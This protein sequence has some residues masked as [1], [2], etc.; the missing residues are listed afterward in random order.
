MTQNNSNLRIDLFDHL[1]VQVLELSVIND[2]VGSS[3]SQ[4]IKHNAR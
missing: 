1:R 4:Y 2:L 3:G